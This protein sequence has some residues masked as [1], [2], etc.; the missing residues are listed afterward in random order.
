MSLNR[1]K[2]LTLGTSQYNGLFICGEIYRCPKFTQI[3]K[4]L[5]SQIC[6]ILFFAKHVESLFRLKQAERTGFCF[7]LA[8]VTFMQRN[9]MVKYAKKSVRPVI[10]SRSVPSEV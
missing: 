9:L 7:V 10:N 3:L 4:R 8:H 5:V 1:C 6:L 2:R